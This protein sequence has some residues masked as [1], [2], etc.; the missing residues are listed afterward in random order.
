VKF[1]LDTQVSMGGAVVCRAAFLQPYDRQRFAEFMDV[2]Q[3]ALV[4]LN[5]QLR[6]IPQRGSEDSALVNSH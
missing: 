3:S 6:R 5:E 2:W 1:S 4:C